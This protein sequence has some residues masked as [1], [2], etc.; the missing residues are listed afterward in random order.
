ME[1]IYDHFK[2]DSYMAFST[3]MGV[4]NMNIRNFNT[5]NT[6]SFLAQSKTYNTWWGVHSSIGNFIPYCAVISKKNMDVLNGYDERYVKGVGY[7]DYD[8]THRVWN[9]K[10]KMQ[11]IDD[12]FVFHQ[13]HKPT[14]YPN[15]INLDLLNK[16]NKEQPGRIKANVASGSDF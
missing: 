8:F 10:L 5:T 16:L 15:T 3:L 1:Y 2:E 13:W 6:E 14:N 7:D 11:C 12:P 9:L 4:K